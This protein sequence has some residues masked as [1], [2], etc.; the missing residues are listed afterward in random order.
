MST[1]ALQ[2]GGSAAASR[3]RD[4]GHGADA[5]G[6]GQRMR[7][8]SATVALASDLNAEFPTVTDIVGLAGV[9][10]KTFYEQFA[11]RSDCLLTAI[12]HALSI[13]T[14]RVCAGHEADTGW[15]ESMR[16]GLTELLRFFDEEPQLARL[17]VVRCAAAGP[18]ALARRG[19]ALDQLA[20]LADEGRKLARHQPPPL[21][22]E[23]VVGGVM[24]VIT[25]RL[26]SDERAPLLE[27]VNPLMSVIVLPYRGHAVSGREL[28]RSITP[29]P[30]PVPAA[31]E[32]HAL[33][34]L[35]MRLTNRTMAVLSA[36]AVEPGLSNRDV[37]LRAGV[38]DQ[39]QIS[40]LLKRLARLGLTEN[41]GHGQAKGAT[42]EWFLTP[43]GGEVQET[44]ERVLQ[45]PGHSRSGLRGGGAPLR[46]SA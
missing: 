36:I 1:L 27:L 31:A 10:R 37:G 25:K 22:A 11:D 5:V 30:A 41:R 12:E 18:A 29:E 13:A 43:R 45:G 21:T 46:A 16:S 28:V 23:G 40:R 20:R 3:R 42:N 15:A 4:A 33:D 9:S 7:L 24:G 26:V 44:L 38:S 32:R 34:G 2:R 17:C 35:H 39:G 8:I 14:E 6:A 19:E